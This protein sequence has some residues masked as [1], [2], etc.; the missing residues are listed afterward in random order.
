MTLVKA[1]ITKTILNLGPLILT[2]RA[3]MTK[4]L[5]ILDKVKVVVLMTHVRK[6]IKILKKNVPSRVA[7]T[8]VIVQVAFLM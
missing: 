8:L 6:K 1:V 5:K 4:I 3:T 7:T 2:T